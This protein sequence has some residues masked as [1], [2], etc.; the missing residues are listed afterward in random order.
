MEKKCMKE[1]R[2]KP[3]SK[4]ENQNSQHNI[5]IVIGS[6]STLELC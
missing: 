6:K 1:Q 5:L 4:K 2:K 3:M